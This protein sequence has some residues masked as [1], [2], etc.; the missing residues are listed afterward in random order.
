MN[1][2]SRK[3]E[4]DMSPEAIDRRLKEASQLNKLGRS[5]F[6]ARKIGKVKDIRKNKE[7]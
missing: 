3:V 1:N 6:T 4:V 2:V 5:I 7:S